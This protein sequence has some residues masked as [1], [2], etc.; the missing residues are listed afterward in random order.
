MVI[1]FVVVWC[2]PPTVIGGAE[3]AGEREIPLADR[4]SRC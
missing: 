3:V 4:G 1:A 2:V